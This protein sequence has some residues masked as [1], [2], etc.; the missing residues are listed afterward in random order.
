MTEEQIDRIAGTLAK[1][2]REKIP[3]ERWDEF[4]ERCIERET[5]LGE[6]AVGSSDK[7]FTAKLYARVRAILRAN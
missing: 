2:I 3:P 1:D 6:A 5:A 4:I 7:E